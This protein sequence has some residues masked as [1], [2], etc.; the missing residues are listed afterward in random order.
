MINLLINSMTSAWYA[1]QSNISWMSWNLFLALIPLALSFWLFSPPA[2]PKPSKMRSSTAIWCVGLLLGFSLLP[3][4]HRVGRLLYRLLQSL[5]VPYLLIALAI[6]LILMGVGIWL[7]RQNHQSPQRSLGWWL[8]VSVFI[9]FLPNAPYVLTDVIH[10]IDQIRQ[11]YS[12]WII[13]LALIPQYLI[14]IFIGFEA[15]VLSLINLDGYLDRHGWKR[16]RP[17]AELTV[18]ALSAIGIYLG[19]FHRF[20]SWDIIANPDGL[21]RSMIDNL[22]NHRPL[23]VIAVTFVVLTVLY[24][25]M[26]F[27]TLA[28]LNPPSA[29]RTV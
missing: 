29:P 4:I 8:G 17:I 25:L 18:H 9:L 6:T 28:V 22:L 21:M 1:I 10:L 11:G 20:N 14:F 3:N 12:V 15:Y 13:S 24:G 19:R 27:V 26:K 16:K 23:F 7:R 2:P 5:D